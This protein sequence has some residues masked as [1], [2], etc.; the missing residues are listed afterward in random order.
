MYILLGG[1]LAV[2]TA[3]GLNVATLRPVTTAGEMGVITGQPRSATITAAIPSRILVMGKQAFAAVLGDDQA[4]EARVMRN[5]ITMLANK[6]TND[7]VRLR[8][9]EAE[10]RRFEGQVSH[11]D[12][13]LKGEMHRAQA[14]LDFIVEKGIMPRDQAAR[15]VEEKLRQDASRVLIVDD[16]IV[17]RELV[18]DALP[19][20]TVL[21]AADGHQALDVVGD[22]PPDLVIA[23]IAMPGMDGYELAQRLGETHP[24]VPVLAVSGNVEEAEVASRGFKGFVA[25]PLDVAALREVVDL[26]ISDS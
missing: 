10:R 24:E 23:D 26:T 13:Q 25:K 15:Q 18:R 11:L 20:C 19:Y 17:F 7:N 5:F 14:A 21:E 16:E 6:V 2:T 8:E 9:Y 22:E 1:E 4:L 3:E 12:A